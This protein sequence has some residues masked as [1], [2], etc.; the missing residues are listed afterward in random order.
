V[1]AFLQITIGQGITKLTAAAPFGVGAKPSVSVA[2]YGSELRAMVVRGESYC[3]NNE[4]ANKR[5]EPGLCDSTPTST[6]FVLS[7]TYGSIPEF[8]SQ[9]STGVSPSPCSSFLLHGMYDMGSNVNVALYTSSTDIGVVEVHEG[10]PE[11][12]T[13]V[14]YCGIADAFA[15]AVLDAWPLVDLRFPIPQELIDDSSF[16][17]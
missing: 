16:L 14:G 12:T 13:D 4:P 11:G 10:V 3:W 5:P 1:A 7:Y 6:P 17:G 9:L 2:L 8:L 15:G